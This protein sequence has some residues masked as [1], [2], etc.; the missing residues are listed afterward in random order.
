[1]A[2]INDQEKKVKDYVKKY[3]KKGYPK[4][5]LRKTLLDFGYNKGVVDKVFSS[6]ESKKPTPEKPIKI[7]ES[8]DLKKL[9]WLW[10]SLASIL[11]LIIL[12]SVVLFFLD[13]PTDCKYD[14]QCFIESAKQGKHVIVKEDVAGS[15]LQY[16]YKD[17]IITKEFVSFSADEPKEVVDL[18]KGK[19]MTCPFETFN[20]EVVNGVFGGSENCTGNLLD[21]IYEL[22]IVS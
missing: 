1:M 5:S 10:Y 4:D 18:F 15:M 3:I 22:K 11:I 20:E 9:R 2:D 13:R 17:S 21:V 16:S 14:K 8:L 19:T 6:S 7:K 12:F